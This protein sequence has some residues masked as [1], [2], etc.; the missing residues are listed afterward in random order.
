MQSK[1]SNLFRFC[2]LFQKVFKSSVLFLLVFVSE[3][4]LNSS[5]LYT[6]EVYPVPPGAHLPAGTCLWHSRHKGLARGPK[7]WPRGKLIILIVHYYD[8][9]EKLQGISLHNLPPQKLKF[10][11]KIFAWIEKLDIKMLVCRKI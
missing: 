9:S 3:W 2:C 1:K 7:D 11:A 10:L 5:P 8:C 4:A 6:G